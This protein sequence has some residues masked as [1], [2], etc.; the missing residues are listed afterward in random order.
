M[1]YFDYAAATPLAP[2][3]RAV[4]EAHLNNI[5]ANPAS[6]HQ[7]GQAALRALEQARERVRAFIDAT[8][9][10]EIIFTASA[11]ESNN[12]ALRG[13]ALARWCAAGEPTHIITSAIEHPSVLEP[14]GDLER[15]GFATV[16]YISPEQSGQIS[17]EAIMKAIR[18]ETALISLHLVNSEIGA[19]QPISALSVALRQLNQERLLRFAQDK[20]PPVLLHSDA[21]QAPLTEPV[22]LKELGVDLLTLSAHKIYGPRGAALLFVRD[23]VSLEPLLSGG[24]QEAGVR[25][26]TENVAAI[27]G[28]A[29]ALSLATT[30]HEKLNQSCLHLRETL[31]SALRDRNISFESNGATATPRITNLWFPWVE[32]QELLIGL[33]QQGIAVSAGS[34]CR[35]RAAVPSP[36]VVAL[37]GDTA[38]ARR[39]I[40]F[41]FGRETTG[42]DITA[43]VK[44]IDT[45]WT[46]YNTD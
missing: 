34:A 19:I 14:F 39:S 35:A 15:L 28:F 16:T 42:A 10:S 1:H 46:R 9:S 11:T 5:F 12:L 23:G 36:V 2:E 31:L 45:L 18:P 37:F 8:K 40:R 22:S 25:A 13:V 6:L 17:V 30:Q 27:V 3:V 7:A 32:A 20:L 29:E 33:D 4:M 41:S 24:D 26:G 44:A 21:A 43:L 38:R